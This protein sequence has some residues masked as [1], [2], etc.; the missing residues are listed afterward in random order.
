MFSCF[1]KANGTNLATSES[2]I[3][4]DSFLKN[5]AALLEQLIVSFNGKC[6]PNEQAQECSEALRLPSR[7]LPILINGFPINGNLSFSLSLSLSLYM[8]KNDEGNKS[9]DLKSELRIVTG[10]AKAVAYLHHGLS[11]T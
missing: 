11:R 8:D 7:Q 4:E 9:F 5:G 3:S 6:N 10:I 2:K 1:T